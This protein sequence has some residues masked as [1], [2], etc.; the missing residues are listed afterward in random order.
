MAAN[1]SDQDV[2][3]LLESLDNGDVTTKQEPS[4][5]NPAT[6]D[7][8]GKDDDDIL[9][10]LDSLTDSS[11]PKEASKTSEAATTS[12]ASI[13]KE[14]VA[15]ANTVEPKN[16]PTK[17]EVTPVAAPIEKVAT[18][19]NIGNYNK[20]AE[21]ESAPDPIA[22][23]SSWWQ[24][25]ATG[26]WDSA[27]SAVKQAEAK[28]RE[29]QPEVVQ[30]QKH[31]LESLNDSMSKFKLGGD[32]IQ[33]T[34]SSVLDTIAPPISRH[35]QLQIY[36]FHDMIGY[37]S[38]DDIVYSVFERVMQQVEGGGSLSMTVQK[39]KE[40][41]AAKNDT[42]K[43][44][45]N[46]F[47]GPIDHAQKL[48]A[49]SIDEF[50]RSDAYA[51]KKEALSKKNVTVDEDG[52]ISESHDT[53]KTD[54]SARISNICLSIQP[55]S[56]EVA[57]PTGSSQEESNLIFSGSTH[58][59]QFVIYLKDPDHNIEISTVS[60]SFP[61]QWAKWLDSSDD[62]L[63][64][65]SVDPREWVIDWIEEGLGLSMGVLA[66]SYVCR[67][68]GITEATTVKTAEQ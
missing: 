26:F 52:R 12:T 39:G 66:Q 22:S 62:E 4:S 55:S 49:A 27:A 43:R 61:I 58:T 11:K 60:Q 29:L 34:L 42:D 57:V 18:S 30:T 53:Q 25:S 14:T 50:L 51:A 44:E 23:L 67:R 59:F 17:S 6:Y 15:K 8:K 65:S 32:L 40:R 54:A 31:A 24:K 45:L 10:F 7:N 37:S 35:E 38:I 56:A 3:E 63:D 20:P 47:K 33:S 16:E 13:N 2:F 21:T 64:L 28:V 36:V 48:A 46:L 68:M 1:N 9:G 5:S 41:H 19:N